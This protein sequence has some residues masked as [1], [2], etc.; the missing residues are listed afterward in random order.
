MMRAKLIAFLL[1]TL[2]PAALRAEV[3]DRIL[4]VAAGHAVT[5]SAALIDA[6]CEAFLAARPPLQLHLGDEGAISRLQPSVAHLADQWVMET[7]RERSPLSP[8]LSEDFSA[9]VSDAWTQITDKFSS[10]EALDEE[11]REYGLDESM[12]RSRLEREQRLLA[13]MDFSLRPQ[14]RVT[15]DQVDAYYRDEF[16]PGFASQ[17]PGQE[18]PSLDEVRSRV[19]EILTQRQINDLLGPWI[20]SLRKDYPVRYMKVG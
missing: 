5:W 9:Q 4:A 6:N 17:Q 18:P 13:F 2:L 7:A 16:L 20:E 11:L 8:D 1:A 3:V 10:R 15:A 12:L 14:V 19:E